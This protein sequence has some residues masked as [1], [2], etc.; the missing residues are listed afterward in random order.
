MA[1]PVWVTFIF[2]SHLYNYTILM[3][4][5]NMNN[6]LRSVVQNLCSLLKDDLADFNLENG[7]CLAVCQEVLTCNIF[8]ILWNWSA[9]A[10]L[11]VMK[12]FF[13]NQVQFLPWWYHYNIYFFIKNSL[14]CCRC[15]IILK[16]SC[17]YFNLIYCSWSQ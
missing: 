7:E 12:Y 13:A 11:M 10:Y 3:S 8:N 9:N 2:Y 16:S 5:K 17:F 15:Q 14:R 1:I 4:W 6:K